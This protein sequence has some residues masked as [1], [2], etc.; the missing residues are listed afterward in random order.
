[1]NATRDPLHGVVFNGT[2]GSPSL[3]EKLRG[4][5]HRRGSWT[6]WSIVERAGHWR[7]APSPRFLLRVD[8]FPRWDRGL[9]GF[10]A[11]HAIM[12]DAGIRYLLG[13][14][15]HPAENPQNPHG[16][17]GRA[18]TSEEAAVLSEISPEVEI[19]LHGWT[20]RRGAG[21]VAAE[22]V[23][24]TA[25]E[26]DDQLQSGLDV[27]HAAG[28]TSQAYIPPYNAVDRAAFA[29]LARRFAIVFGG[30]ES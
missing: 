19:A 4:V 20:H 12:R 29:V 26:L 10:R 22:I 11:F 5:W 2:A 15:P 13:V 27:L 3:L 21:P 6:H 18:W 17:S 7:D 28:L 16:R 8:D 1:M 14:I 30:P 25:E 9:E 23:G 24:C